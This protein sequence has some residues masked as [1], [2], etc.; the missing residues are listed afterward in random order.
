MLALIYWGVKMIFWFRARDGVVSLAALVVWVGSVAALSIICFNEGVSFAQTG[1]TTIKTH[2]P[3]SPDTLY[4]TTDHKIADLKYE[5][6]I[7]F[8]HEEYSVFL[9]EEKKELYISPYFSIE[10]SEDKDTRL[11][12][13][14][15][16]SG[17]TDYDAVKKAEGIQYNYSLRSDSLNIDEYF[18]IPSDRK[19]A[20]D[21]L[22]IDLYIPTGTILKFDVPSRILFHSHFINGNEEYPESRRESGSGNWVMT[23]EGLEPLSDNNRKQK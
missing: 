22:G 9:N 15:K 12:V 13:R 6:Q 3:K 7:S 19:W 23:N 8:G 21:E 5:K 16:S 14:K 1:S 10:H 17:R 11:E 4:I 20:A 2:L 18:T